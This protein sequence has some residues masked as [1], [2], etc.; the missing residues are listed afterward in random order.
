M[1][2]FQVS[3]KKDVGTDIGTFDS[4]CGAICPH[5]CIEIWNALIDNFWKRDTYLAVTAQGGYIYLVD[6]R[7]S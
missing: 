4:N 2:C 5:H 3:D 6:K 7:I 1:F